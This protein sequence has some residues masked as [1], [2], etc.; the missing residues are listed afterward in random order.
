MIFHFFDTDHTLEFDEVPDFMQS[1]SHCIE[2]FTPNNVLV[3]LT[4]LNIV[5]YKQP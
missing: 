2:I 4:G 5:E 1:Y 3:D